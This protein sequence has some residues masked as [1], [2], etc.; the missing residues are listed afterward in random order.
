MPQR[1]WVVFVCVF[2][3]QRVNLH[4]KMEVPREVAQ[5]K[6]NPHITVSMYLD[7]IHLELTKCKWTVDLDSI[8]VTYWGDLGELADCYAPVGWCGLL[9]A[10]LSCW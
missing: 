5:N 4:D 1:A 6:I 7:V 8:E 2:V 9:G 3:Y 10:L